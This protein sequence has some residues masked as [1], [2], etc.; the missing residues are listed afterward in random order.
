[1]FV[2][3]HPGRTDR[4]NTLASLTFQ[5]DLELPL[6]LEYLR[7]KE[8]MLL[9]Y[10]RRG[11]EQLRQSKE[12]LFSTQNSLKARIGALDGLRDESFLARKVRNESDVRTRFQNGSAKPSAPAVNPWDKIAAAQKVAAGI[13]KPYFYLE[14]AY[15]FD[16]ELFSI[17]RDIVRLAEEKTR[18]NSERL[19]EYRESGLKS[20]ELKIFSDAPIYPEFE[21]VK[22]AHSLAEWRHNMPDDLLCGR[23]LHGLTPTEGARVLVNGSKLADVAFRR[24]L[25]EGGVA[26]V[27]KSTDTMINFALTVDTDARWVRKIYEEQVKS[28]ERTNYAVIARTLFE[29]HGSAVYP[30]ATFT[31][32]LAFGVVKGYVLDGKAVPA[33][34]T[35]GGSF[36]HAKAHGNMPPYELPRSWFQARDMGRLNL[37]TPLNFVCTADIIGGNSG[38]PV[39]NGDNEVVGLIF[40]GNIQSLLLDY[41]YDDKFARAVS[42]DSR[43]IIEALRS[44]Y[45]AD[46]VANELAAP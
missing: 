24:R 3:G 45:H 16:S 30:D 25:V 13:M 32:R 44:I 11:A 43:A 20:L 22:L 23:V 34:T 40:D 14:R 35:I 15:A 38:S 4:I 17:A 36:A 8:K 1:M 31:L 7:N 18:P 21:T 37:A 9:D 46:R 33:Y 42:V 26:A 6:R 41:G 28:V 5:R 19:E 2:A 29:E 12:E 10:G 39:V 27:Q